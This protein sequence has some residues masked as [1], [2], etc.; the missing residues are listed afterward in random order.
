MEEEEGHTMASL[1]V[2]ASSEEERTPQGDHTAATDEK[3]KNARENSYTF[4]VVFGFHVFVCC[5]CYLTLISLVSK[6]VW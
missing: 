3:G 1:E 6:S 4:V 2:L 5:C